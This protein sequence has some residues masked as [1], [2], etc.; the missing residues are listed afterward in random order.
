LETLQ[1]IRQQ[2][3]DFEMIFIGGGEDMHLVQQAAAQYPWIHYVGP[4]FDR[5]KVP[6]YAVSKVFLMPGLIGLGILDTF[7]METPLITTDV[8]IHSPEIEYLENGVNGVMVSNPEN[9]LTY[10]KAVVHLLQNEIE[11][12]KLVNGCRLARERYT[13]DNMV[14]R[15]ADG[16]T[17]ALKD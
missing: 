11:R 10:A 2:V 7:A 14:E 13:L 3:P 1:L 17:L 8:P 6:Y 4:K 15:F 12:Q 5:E 16:V 9:P